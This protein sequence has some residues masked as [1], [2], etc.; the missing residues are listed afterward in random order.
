MKSYEKCK[1]GDKT[2]AF[3]TYFGKGM[4]DMQLCP[5][6]LD[7]LRNRETPAPANMIG[8]LPERPENGPTYDPMDDF[9]EPE[10]PDTMVLVELLDSVLLHEVSI[11][12]FFCFS[13]FCS[14]LYYYITS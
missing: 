14:N 4:L 10:T 3:T 5:W 7:K 8:G 11:Y 13:L 12:V 6:F 9:R 1:N 2:L